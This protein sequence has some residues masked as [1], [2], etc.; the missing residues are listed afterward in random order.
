[1][2]KSQELHVQQFYSARGTRLHIE[3]PV[4]NPLTDPNPDEGG[5][6]VEC[7]RIS[8]GVIYGIDINLHAV[9][10]FVILNMHKKHP[11]YNLPIWGKVSDVNE[12]R[13]HLDE[14]V[15][16]NGGWRVVD[17]DKTKF[18]ISAASVDSFLIAKP[19][20]TGKASTAVW[21]ENGIIG[22]RFHIHPRRI[23]SIINEMLRIGYASDVEYA[24]ELAQPDGMVF[25]VEEK[26]T[27]KPLR[28]TLAEVKDSEFLNQQQWNKLDVLAATTRKGYMFSIS[29]SV[30][31]GEPEIMI[32]GPSCTSSQTPLDIG[33]FSES[34]KA[35]AEE[36]RSLFYGDKE[37]LTTAINGWLVNN[38]LT[39][40]VLCLSAIS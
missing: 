19:T 30:P 3:R 1:M 10:G 2:I 12:I 23:P 33:V 36:H 27:S 24:L 5:L 14:Y 13:K 6:T 20:P 18:S 39:K 29:F 35:F 28:V 17:L 8:T 4:E 9:V 38:P 16:N 26:S 34:C 37:A 7:C 40:D 15:D 22:H 25:V 21:I 31:G 32:W 11:L